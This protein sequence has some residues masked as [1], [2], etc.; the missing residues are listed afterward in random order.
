MISDGLWKVTGDRQ[1]CKMDTEPISQGALLW[2]RDYKDIFLSVPYLLNRNNSQGIS[3]LL[4]KFEGVDISQPSY[5]VCL[6][7]D[8]N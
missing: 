8:S 4:A 6:G 3:T 7:L 5:G 1:V 2:W